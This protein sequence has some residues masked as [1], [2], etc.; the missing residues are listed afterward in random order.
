MSQTQLL[1]AF[2]DKCLFSNCGSYVLHKHKRVEKDG[3]KK[4]GCNFPVA[5]A[6]AY[7]GNYTTAA[8]LQ[9]CAR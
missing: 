3:T 5:G 2:V 8:K 7:V 4:W 9:K 6:V 1:A